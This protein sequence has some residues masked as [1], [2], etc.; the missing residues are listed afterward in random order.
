MFWFCSI[1]P[2]N[3]TISTEIEWP[4]P[5]FNIQRRWWLHKMIIFWG[6]EKACD[7]TLSWAAAEGRPINTGKQQR[8]TPGLGCAGKT[9][10]RRTRSRER[11][12]WSRSRSFERRMP[13]G[14]AQRARLP[15]FIRKK[16]QRICRWWPT[17]WMFL[18][19]TIGCCR[20]FVFFAIAYLVL[21]E[22]CTHLYLFYTHGLADRAYGLWPYA[23]TFIFCFPLWAHFCTVTFRSLI[24]CF[25]W[26]YYR[27]RA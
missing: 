21:W 13:G 14:K 25:I 8:P 17:F 7:N 27:T 11:W 24:S 26:F 5:L 3:W 23:W 2:K 6:P 22:S 10:R 12:C 18:T 19:L 20:Y 16:L 15:S 9:Y 4:K 1:L